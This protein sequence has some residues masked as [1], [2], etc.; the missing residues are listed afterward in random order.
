MP[1]TTTTLLVL[2]AAVLTGFVGTRLAAADF[3]HPPPYLSGSNRYQDNPRYAWG[4]NVTIEW[5]NS[6]SNNTDLV[7]ALEFPR[8]IEHPDKATFNLIYENMTSGTTSRTW[9]VSLFGDEALVPAG[10]DA[11]CYFALIFAGTNIGMFSSTYFNVTLPNKAGASPTASSPTLAPTDTAAPSATGD[12][13][14]GDSSS[15]LSHGAAAGI[16]VGVALGCLLILGGLGFVLW[17]RRKA[18]REAARAA[19]A[20]DA[21][22]AAEEQGK[23]QEQ[24]PPELELGSGPQEFFAGAAADGWDKNKPL[25]ISELDGGQSSF[26]H[27]KS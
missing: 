25:V 23:Q 3:V 8:K 12:A 16:G 11:I 6:Y 15:S 7:L 27:E 19:E 9:N 26:V 22:R 14:S 17:R 4:S 13:S 5:R 10:S 18:R 24:Q 20:E 21:S 2:L 1:T